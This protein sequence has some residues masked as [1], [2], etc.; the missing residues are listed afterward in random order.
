MAESP[1]AAIIFSILG[2]VFVLIGGIVLMGIGFLIGA[3]GNLGGLSSLLGGSS[4]LGNISLPSGVSFPGGFGNVTSSA[5]AASG[6]GVSFVVWLGALGVLLGI[7]MMALSVILHMYP[8]R[9]QLWGALILVFSLLSWAGAIGGLL[10]G[11]ILGLVGAALAISW[12]PSAV[13]APVAQVTRIC[14]NCGTVIQPG[15]K[16]CPYCG[17][18][19]P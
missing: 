2:G 17:K 16:F 4:L 13:P 1:T 19:L 18:A 15:M 12:K 11:F 7:A 10:I 5:G 8:A 3:M 14:P 9:H 6:A